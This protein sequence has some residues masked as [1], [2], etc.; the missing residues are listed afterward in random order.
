M[1]SLSGLPCPGCGGTRAM[2]AASR[3]RVLDALAWNPLVALG[4]AAFGAY[5]LYA[6][7][8]L[9][10]RA[11]RRLRLNLRP[12]ARGSVAVR[13]ALLAAVALNWAYLIW[14]GR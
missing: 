6:L 11:P 5:W 7:A 14:V 3:L 12:E 9:A 10:T 4:G 13:L 1:K 2:L 8:A